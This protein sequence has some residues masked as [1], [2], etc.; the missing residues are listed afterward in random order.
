MKPIRK[1]VFQEP[2]QSPEVVAM[3]ERQAVSSMVSE[4]AL[5]G[6]SRTSA[7]GI[8]IALK[9]KPLIIF[10]GPKGSG[11]ERTTLAVAK[12]LVNEKSEQLLKLQGHPWWASSYSNIGLLT[13]AQERLTSHRLRLYLEEAE[14]SARNNSIFFAVFS[15][16]SRA[17]LSTI[18]APLHQQIQIGHMLRI[19]FDLAEELVRLPSNVYLLASMDLNNPGMDV[20]MSQSTCMLFDQ[21]APLEKG[22][23]IQG[24]APMHSDS[25][26]SALFAC[27]RFDPR[28]ALAMAPT[29]G[30][31][32]DPLRPVREFLA[33]LSRHGIRYGSELIQDAYL[34]IGN[35]WDAMGQGLFN[36]NPS[37]NTGEAYNFWLQNAAM[38]K[39]SNAMRGNPDLRSDVKRLLTKQ[40]SL[41]ST[42]NLDLMDHSWLSKWG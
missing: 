10:C 34:Y 2:A 32:L 38:P 24:R 13:N 3:T 30:R 29:P 28:A 40:T 41:T 22:P 39:L 11:K 23:Y 18:F 7:I 37:S 12:T 25:L 14:R 9:S 5:L 19:P 8:W 33:L 16:I 36:Q 1:T 27:R 4:L 17:E 26:Q 35:A 31:G 20:G 15:K 21:V 6:V 42:K